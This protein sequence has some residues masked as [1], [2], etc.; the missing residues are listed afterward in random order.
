M[1]RSITSISDGQR[2]NLHAQ[3]GRSL[4][5][6]IDCLVRQKSVG[7]VPLRK[8]R[9]R[10]DR[11]I[12][13]AHAMM[14]F[15]AFLQPAKNGN[16]IF[17]GGLANLHGLEAPL[18][19]G[20]LL[21]VFAIFVDGGRTDRAQFAPRQWWLQHVRRVHRTFR[22]SR[23]HQRMQFVDEQND[24]P[25]G[26]A[27]FLQHGLQ[28]VLEF[29]AVFRSG[30]QRSKIERHNAL[31]L[32]HF[33]HI[34][35]HN[36]LRQSFHN[37]SFSHSRFAN[38][39]RIV[40]RA[41]R[42][43]LHHAADFFVAP[44]HGIELSSPRKVRQIARILLQRSICRFRIL[45]SHAMASANRRHRL[46]NRLMRSAFAYQ[47]LPS[48]IAAR[49]CNAQQDVLGGD[50]LVL[51]SLCFV[52]SALQNLIRSRA[53]V[54]LRHARNFR[55]PRNLLF[56]LARQPHGRHSELFQQRRNHAVALRR[57]RPKQV[58]RLDLLLPGTPAK[59][60]RGRQRFLSLHRQFV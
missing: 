18:E 26:F 21:D 28:S 59:F 53:Q 33:R 60:L 45:R 49:S 12:L 38:Q 44:N 57:Q 46:Q 1:R 4:V 10:H 11:R 37:R 36:S 55:Q 14:N 39:H 54:L 52:K 16:R 58:Q 13:D 51:Q 56:N 7:D 35:G 32:Q 34:A 9:G 50:V 2:I 40:L 22:R 20:I 29:A 25:V 30:H 27:H 41:P 24:L 6:Q 8:H 42:Q 17:N 23:A 5:N 31:R 43:N 48:G 19:R 15:V 47:Q 3:S